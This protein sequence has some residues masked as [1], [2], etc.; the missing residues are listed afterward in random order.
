MAVK[1]GTKEERDTYSLSLDRA[2]VVVPPATPQPA[3]PSKDR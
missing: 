2:P 3:A 1:F